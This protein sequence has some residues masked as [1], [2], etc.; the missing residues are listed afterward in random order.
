M[1]AYN[2]L[3]PI[4]FI[5]FNESV[6]AYVIAATSSEDAEKRARAWYIDINGDLPDLRIT[7][8]PQKYPGES[9]VNVG[10]QR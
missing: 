10:R 6:F 8:T 3:M 5:R 9:C 1:S 2:S 7:V 4:F